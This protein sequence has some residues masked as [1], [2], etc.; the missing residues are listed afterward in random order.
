LLIDNL[1]EEPQKTEVD[2]YVDSTAEDIER[3]TRGTG[4][5]EPERLR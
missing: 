3:G 1:R 2:V 5:R 4:G